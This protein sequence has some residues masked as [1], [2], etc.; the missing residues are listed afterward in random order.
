MSVTEAGFFASPLVLEGGG[1]LAGASR[2]EF[3]EFCQRNPDVRMERNGAGD[4]IIMTPAGSE[5]G[6]RSGEAFYQLTAWSKQNGTGV[7]FDASTGFGLPKGGERS[8]DAS[9]VLRTRWDALTEAERNKYA[10]L[11]PDFVIEVRSESERLPQLREKM[12]EYA[13]NGVRLGWLIDPFQRRVEIYRPGEAPV[14]IDNPTTISGNPELPG[15]TLEL[16]PIW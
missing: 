14:G 11:A 16:A 15:F 4:L 2:D 12:Q 3:F 13:D 9:W 7:T 6:R 10:P 5:S 8:P 1:R